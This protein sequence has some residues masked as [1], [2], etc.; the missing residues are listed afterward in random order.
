MTSKSI[1][2][3]ND[4]YSLKDLLNHPDKS[5]AMLGIVF[6]ILGLKNDELGEEIKAWNAKCVFQGSNVRTKI[7]TS[8][9]DLFEETS[10]AATRLP[11]LLL[12]EL[13]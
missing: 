11:A 8:A 5:E 10:N 3:T 2:D 12:R 9:A 7:G 6:S 4:V 1:W 13:R